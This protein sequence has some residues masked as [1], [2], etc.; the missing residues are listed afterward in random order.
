MDLNFNGMDDFFFDDQYD[1]KSKPRD[2]V[3]LSL[4]SK[5]DNFSFTVWAKNLTDEKYAVRGYTFVLEPNTESP[6]NYKS[7]GSPRT[8]GITIGYSI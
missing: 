1:Y 7:F 5:N 4:T 2:L 6:K 8:I 3:D